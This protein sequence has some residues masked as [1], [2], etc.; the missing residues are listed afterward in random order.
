MVEKLVLGYEL[1]AIP[2]HQGQ[3]IKVAT[4]QLNG[5]I[6]CNQAALAGVQNETFESE[7]LHLFR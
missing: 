6:A 5:L 4:I 1:A 7:A 3:R 2:H